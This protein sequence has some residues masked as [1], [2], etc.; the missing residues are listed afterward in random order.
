[1][2][3]RSVVQPQFSLRGHQ[4]PVYKTRKVRVVQPANSNR[5]KGKQVRRFRRFKGAEEKCPREA[6]HS[7]KRASE[8]TEIRRKVSDKVRVAYRQVK[9]LK[10]KQVRWLRRFN[11]A[12]EK[13]LESHLRLKI[14]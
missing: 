9:G 12:E 2:S 10:G 1:M 11:N 5:L 13:S 8:V 6:H 14:L 4:Y 3:S 7:L